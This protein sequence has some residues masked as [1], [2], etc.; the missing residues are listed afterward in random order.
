MKLVGKLAKGL[1]IVGAVG[2][3]ILFGAV[4][5]CLMASDFTNGLPDPGPSA[6]TASLFGALIGLVIGIASAIHYYG[7]R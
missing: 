3:C 7:R 5:G 6:N 1:G 4:G 2:S